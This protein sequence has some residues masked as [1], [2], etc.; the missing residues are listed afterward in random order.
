[1]NQLEFEYN[2]DGV[3]VQKAVKRLDPIEEEF[4]IDELKRQGKLPITE[5]QLA[6]LQERAESL[7]SHL[8]SEDDG[9]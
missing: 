5:K 4:V 1:M 8:E 6:E 7:R 2:S 9:D 3:R